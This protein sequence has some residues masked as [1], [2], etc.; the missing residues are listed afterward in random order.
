MCQSKDQHGIGEGW[1][2]EEIKQE[3]E[4]AGDDLVL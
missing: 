4:G 2:M 3:G 1:A